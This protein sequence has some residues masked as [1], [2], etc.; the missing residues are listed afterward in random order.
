M[1]E[2][3]AAFEAPNKSLLWPEKFCIIRNPSGQVAEGN[4]LKVEYFSPVGST[5]N[6]YRIAIWKPDSQLSYQAVLGHPFTGGAT[7]TVTPK[8]KGSQLHW[9]GKYH[10]R[11]FSPAAL[12]FRFWFEDRFFAALKANLNRRWP[13]E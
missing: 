7:I 1:Q 3:K 6:P 5:L 8:G 11:G 12:F 13:N 10:Y 9:Q 2:L 4:Q